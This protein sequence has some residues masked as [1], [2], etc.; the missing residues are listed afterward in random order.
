MVVAGIL[1]STTLI[2]VPRSLSTT[3]TVYA[4]ATETTT[5]T[6]TQTMTLA[7]VSTRSAGINASNSAALLAA[8]ASTHS[9]STGYVVIGP[10]SPAIVCLQLY[11]FNSNSSIDLNT[12]GLL[13]VGGSEEEF[14]PSIGGGN[15]TI[16]TSQG[17]LTLGG[18]SNADEGTTVAYAITA[19]PGASG[20]YALLIDGWNVPGEGGAPEECPSWGVLFAG[21]GEPDYAMNGPIGSC[22]TIVSSAPPSTPQPF[23]IPGVN[24]VTSNTLYFNVVAVIDSVQ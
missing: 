6:A 1:V 17:Q 13:S 20:Q 15:F 12:T 11:E 19:K 14:G 5:L 18:P 7:N 22:I 16:Q 8:C 4:T 3:T 10:S 21:N 2:L 24:Y 23:S 9:T